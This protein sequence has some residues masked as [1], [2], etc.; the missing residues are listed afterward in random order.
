MPTKRVCTIVSL[1]EIGHCDIV[2][3]SFSDTPNEQEVTVQM[4]GKLLCGLQSTTDDPHGLGLRTLALLILF[5][6]DLC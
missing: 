3:L 2:C 5:T 4:S 6:T 1:F